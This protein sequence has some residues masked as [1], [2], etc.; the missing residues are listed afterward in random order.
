MIELV[1]VSK[2]YEKG[3]AVVRALDEVSLE[4][5]RGSFVA[6]QGPSGSGKST[7]MNIVGLLD[8]PDS[9][10][11][12]LDG[13]DVGTLSSDDLAEVRNKRIGFVFQ[14]FLCPRP[15]RS[16]TSSCPSSIRI[17]RTSRVS[18]WPH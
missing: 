3:S 4:I 10:T 13:T 8:R 7:M 11:Y 16:R 9:G 17:G 15:P 14:S 5:E 6:I 12:E 18:A 2:T 1:D